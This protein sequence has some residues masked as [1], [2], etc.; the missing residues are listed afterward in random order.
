MSDSP[1][2]SSSSASPVKP[3]SP[4]KSRKKGVQQQSLFSA[5]AKARIHPV[6]IYKFSLSGHDDA[7]I[8]LGDVSAGWS[9][10]EHDGEP[11]SPSIVTLK[12]NDAVSEHRSAFYSAIQEMRASHS[13]DQLQPS[14]G[15]RTAAHA[16]QFT[17][18]PVQ[19]RRSNTSP[20]SSAESPLASA[21]NSIANS[22][23][24]RFGGRSK[25]F[26][27]SARSL[28]D[29]LG[30]EP[31][32]IH[33]RVESAVQSTTTVVSPSTPSRGR[34]G[35][36]GITSIKQ[37]EEDEDSMQI[38][39]EPPLAST[40]TINTRAR[41]RACKSI[42]NTDSVELDASPVKTTRAASVSINVGLQLQAKRPSGPR[43]ASSR[44]AGTGEVTPKR[45]SRA[46]TGV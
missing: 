17:L 22:P 25:S 15:Q 28:M 11:V 45:G 20:S 29:G 37:T 2:S 8:H 32:F 6:P 39:F 46:S 3:A 36:K 33:S 10:S 19:L 30:I 1:M 26:D 14:H 9:A 27:E 23:L 12:E 40:S 31:T 18:P 38:D 13:D 5:A 44:R 35:F 4:R 42:E 16:K 34:Q 7:E 43:P 24:A 41:S 21:I